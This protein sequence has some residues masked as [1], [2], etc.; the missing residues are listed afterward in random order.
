MSEDWH[1][2][3]PKQDG[4]TKTPAERYERHRRSLIYGS[5]ERCPLYK[6][7]AIARHYSGLALLALDLMEIL[8][9]RRD[10]GCYGEIIDQIVQQFESAVV[11]DFATRA[12]WQS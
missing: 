3:P 12:P 10:D 9:A 2:P 1:K 4:G 8:K 11:K 7:E 5:F 6:A